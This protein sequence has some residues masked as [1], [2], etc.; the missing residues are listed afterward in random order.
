[1]N[2]VEE[3][4]AYWEN[5]RKKVRAALAKEQEQKQQETRHNKWSAALNRIREE[6]A[7]RHKYIREEV[8]WEREHP[9]Q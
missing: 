3:R 4:N 7:Y 9:N 1:M 6:R 5:I 2:E 8:Q